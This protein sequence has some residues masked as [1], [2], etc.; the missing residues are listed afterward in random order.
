MSNEQINI[1]E[2]QNNILVGIIRYF[3]YKGK[4]ND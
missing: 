2:L 3:F 1:F 4:W